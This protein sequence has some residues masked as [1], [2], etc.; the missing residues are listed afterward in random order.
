M[1][2]NPPQV[3]SEKKNAQIQRRRIV[4]ATGWLVLGTFLAWQVLFSQPLVNSRWETISDF[5]EYWSAA[6][7]LLTGKN[8]YSPEQ[9]LPLE[10]SAGWTKNEPL[11]IWIPPWTLSFMLPF[12]LLQYPISQV[13]WFVLHAGIV[14]FCADWC[15]RFYGGP[16]RYGWIACVVSF[17]F[18]PTLLGLV[19]GQITPL[20]LLGLIGFL[21]FQQ[22]SQWM[23]AGGCL[24]LI[25][26]KP[27]L[28]YLFWLALILWAYD[29]R[30]WF[31]LL[32]GAIAG[33]SAIVI[34]M[35]L[36]HALLSHYLNVFSTAANS[37]LNW[38]TP[39]PGTFLRVIFGME[40]SW[41]QFV[42]AV[43]GII[44]F[45][46]YWKKHRSAW[47]W[48]QQMPLLLLVCLSTTVYTWPHDQVLLIPVLMEVANW[49]Y[50][51]R[52]PVVTGLTVVIY[53]LIN[54][55][56]LTFAVLQLLFFWYIWMVPALLI[57][58]LALRNQIS[59]TAISS[60]T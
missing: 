1:T 10:Q 15:W 30:M 20:M 2:D 5:A 53:V 7:L 37:P 51:D 16:I 27:H 13:L 57:A 12:G 32:G 45:L 56:A 39:T 59:R 9:L 38:K 4:L 11:L 36:D 22:R 24:A 17:T 14:L 19:F 50:Y 21:H 52:R 23:R 44:W 35:T 33:L 47:E 8:P 41:L 46:P 6:R 49:I 3:N 28:L 34:P 58:Y 55:V 42:P 26:I 40:K 29:R 54:A 25:A 43:L 18:L 31:L 60:R 48:S